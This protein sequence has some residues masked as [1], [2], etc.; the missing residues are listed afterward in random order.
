M[1]RR[2]SFA[3]WLAGAAAFA[4]VA[5]ALDG[6]ARAEVR[7]PP[8]SPASRVTQ[9]VGLTQISLEY[10]S[11]A[12]A[13]RRIWSAV[14]TPGVLWRT[15]EGTV[16]KIRFSRE[17][18]VGGA[19]LPAGTYALLTIPSDGDWTVILNRDG[20][21]VG[22]SDYRPELDAA[23]VKVAAAPAPYRERLAFSFSG[24]TD[25]V[26]SLDLEWGDL[27]VSIPIRT[28]THEQIEASIR[29]LDSTW[30]RYAD[31]ARYLHEVKHDEGAALRYIQRSVALSENPYNLTIRASILGDRGEVSPPASPTIPKPALASSPGGLPPPLVTAAPPLVLAS[32][33]PVHAPAAFIR[34]RSV[35]VRGGDAVTPAKPP[36]ASEIS[37][38]IKKGRSDIQGCYQRALRQDPSLTRARITISIDIGVSGL[39]KN[40]K[41]DPPH[42]SGTLESC[43]KDVISHWI[44]PLSPV[45][46]GTEFPVVL[47]GKE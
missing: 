33:E 19:R 20:K 30:R 32:V 45:E 28:F 4:L 35:R 13:G 39:V 9:T 12:A 14:A 41:L 31:T 7:L 21:L 36:G 2:V 27:R 25:E 34:E 16:P 29:D 40:V 43:I 5:A 42:P 17:V 3:P 22:T 47:R 15:G 24:F 46:Y 6:A 11:P 37:P 44:F 38:L 23:R 18:D 26:A 8:R 10:N 1:Q